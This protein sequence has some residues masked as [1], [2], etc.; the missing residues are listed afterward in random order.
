LQRTDFLLRHAQEHDQAA[1]EL[2]RFEDA[3]CHELPAASRA[4]CPLVHDVVGIT[5][6]P[7]GVRVAFAEAVPGSRRRRAHAILLRASADSERDL[8]LRIRPLARQQAA[9]APAVR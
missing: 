8:E 1:A 9:S 3:A 2:E 7:G 5:D 4:A 6:V